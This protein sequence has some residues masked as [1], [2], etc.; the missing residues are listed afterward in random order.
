[1][2]LYSWANGYGLLAARPSDNNS[3]TVGRTYYATDNFTLYHDNG[4]TW[5]TYV[6]SGSLGADLTAL[7]ALNGT[8]FAR[9]AG[10]GTWSIVAESGSGSVVRATSPTIVTPT[11]AKLANLT[12]NGFLR[13]SAGDGT[14]SVVNTADFGVPA[15][16]MYP[17]TTNGA[18]QTKIE[19]A[20]NDQNYYALEYDQSTIEYAEFMWIPPANWNASTVTFAVGW[21]AAAGT[22]D[23]IWTLQGRGY[24]DGD[25]IDQAWGSGVDVTDTLT[26]AD[27]VHISSTSS[28]VTIGGTL[29]AGNPVFFRVSRKASD[30]SDTLN[31]DARLIHARLFYGIS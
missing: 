14:L 4:T 28:A 2:A 15:S 16:G 17:S 12:T 5:D 29:A 10:A 31:A 23:V 11:I 30:G 9:Q 22:G 6:F 19:A 21:T 1:M 18:A 13:T 3:T 7:E 8:G 26:T 25:A 20:T 24:A 27:D